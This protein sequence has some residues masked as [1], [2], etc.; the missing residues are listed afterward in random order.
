[1]EISEVL[2]LLNLGQ[3]AT[4]ASFQAFQIAISNC[5]G[6]WGENKNLFWASS[7]FPYRIYSDN[8]ST[9]VELFHLNRKLRHTKYLFVGVTTVTFRFIPQMYEKETRNVVI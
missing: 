8:V 2:L 7:P 5:D 9:T 1:M 4:R 3:V 6:Y